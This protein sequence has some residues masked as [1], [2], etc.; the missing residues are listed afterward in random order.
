MVISSRT[1][2]GQPNRCSVCQ[3]EFSIDPS[4]PP[5]DAP[6]PHCGSLAWWPPAVPPL[7][8]DS[9]IFVVAAMYFLDDEDPTAEPSKM[10]EFRRI[11]DVKPSCRVVILDFQKTPPLTPSQADRLV[12]VSEYFRKTGTQLMLAIP[13]AK[14]R[15]K[16][17]IR[18]KS[19][20]S[21]CVIHKDVEAALAQV[22]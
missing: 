5:G 15:L 13:N 18:S 16:R 10:P 3:A 12:R 20:L 17:T 22:K 14:Q 6:C 21:A 7:E 1:P 19:L 8:D 9:F 11:N 2:E 4:I